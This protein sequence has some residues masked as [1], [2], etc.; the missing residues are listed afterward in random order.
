MSKRLLREG[1]SIEAERIL[2][3]VSSI[4]MLTPELSM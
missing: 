3:I 2:E 1:F 4:I